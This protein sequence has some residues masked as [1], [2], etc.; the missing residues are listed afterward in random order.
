MTKLFKGIRKNTNMVRG[1]VDHRN[2]ER[3][4]R[5]FMHKLYEDQNGQPEFYVIRK[6]V[7]KETGDIAVEYQPIG[8]SPIVLAFGEVDEEERQLKINKERN[9]DGRIVIS[10]KE[11]TVG[12]NKTYKLINNIVVVNF[13]EA[14][15]LYDSMRIEGI[16]FEG[17][18][19]RAASHSASM[20]KKSNVFFTNKPA[21]VNYTVINSLTGGM[22][23]K[24]LA[25][26]ESRSSEPMTY[27]RIAKID[28][29]ISLCATT[30]SLWYEAG[31]TNNV[32]YFHGSVES[33]DE[34]SELNDIDN[35]FR[36]GYAILSDNIVA[37]IVTEGTGEKVSNAQARRMSPQARIRGAAGKGHFGVYSHNQ[38]M[39][40]I[41]EML[42][43][44][45]ELKAKDTRE[46]KTPKQR[47]FCW[48]DGVLID[49]TNASDATIRRISAKV[50]IIAD[51]DT[52]KWGQYL[53]EMTVIDYL[54]VGI[55]NMSNETT[56]RMGSQIAFKL[57]EDKEEA[58]KYFQA[59]ANRQLVEAEGMNASLQ[60]KK[61][62]VRLNNCTYYNC[63]AVA[64]ETAMFDKLLSNYK[65]K[66]LDTA[67]L[68]KVANLKFDIN[69]K[70]LRMVP[71]D[72]LLNK[73]VEVLGSREVDYIMPTG[74][75]VR[76]KA[77]EVYSAAWERDC[78]QLRNM[79]NENAV[80]TD[81]EKAAVLTN[82]RI[83]I[84]IKSPSQGDNEF[85]ILI[86]VTKEELAA[87]GITMEYGQFIEECPNNCIILAQD[88]TMK[89][90][91]AGS[92]FDGDDMT[93][94]APEFTVLEDGRIVTGLVLNGEIVNDYTSLV[95][96]KR[97]REG[98]VGYAALIKYTNKDYD[99]TKPERR[100]NTVEVMNEIA[101]DKDITEDE[102]NSAF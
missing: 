63:K 29:R 53:R 33:A 55:V 82:S 14:A 43:L 65:I 11:T 88:N 3:L 2:I 92:D 28:T 7:V 35:N 58:V 27:E 99:G 51:K 70:Y 45:E 50:D 9:E 83:M 30:P 8:K 32:F 101:V 39:V 21:S 78:K 46:G 19:Y 59:L 42:A 4:Q 54:E 34:Q 38:R 79:V 80:M 72:H 20:D 13:K 91:L 76:V 44:E 22:L 62:A 93:T 71:E 89:H 66:Q 36:D 16:E 75:V 98:N 15:H 74:E 48:E 81:T 40:E 57:K 12:P 18:L 60:F 86:L 100:N 23:S 69:S 94:I 52:F 90:Q 10:K 5:K 96:R 49:L 26:E 85:E 41:K 31:K 47:C 77:L 84:A 6:L 95:V 97:V 56:G 61:D 68:T 87:R 64:P 73:G 24:A 37:N 17:Q 1:S 102:M 25:Y 67:M